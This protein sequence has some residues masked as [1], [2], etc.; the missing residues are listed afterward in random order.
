MT[1]T[2]NPIQIQEFLGG[3]GYPAEKAELVRAAREQRADS[4]VLRAVEGIPDRTYA[5][6]TEV[7]EAIMGAGRHPERRADPSGNEDSA[8]RGGERFDA[9]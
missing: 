6:P 4:N 5:E 7:S 1:H 2:V 8:E 3:V 9:G